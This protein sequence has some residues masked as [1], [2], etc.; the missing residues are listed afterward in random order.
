VAEIK[1][2]KRG[3]AAERFG[4]ADEVSPIGMEDYKAPQIA[5]RFRE[6]FNLRV[7][8]LKFFQRGQISE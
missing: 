2:L 8:K 6:R 3:K 1:F 4:Q 5:E 7:D